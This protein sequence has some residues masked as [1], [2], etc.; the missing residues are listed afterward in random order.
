[1]TPAMRTPDWQSDDGAIQLHC[2]DCAELLPTI[3]AGAVDAV[4]TD[5]PYGIAWRGHNA[6]TRSWNGI[7]SDDG[8]L[9]L[10]PILSMGCTVV[11]FGANCYPEQLPHRGRWICWDKRTI[12]GAC[13][14]MLGSPFELAWINRKTGF[15]RIYRVMHGGVVNADGHN[16]KRVHPTQKPIALM[17]L[18]IKDFTSEGAIVI[19]PFMGSGTT[20]V[21]CIRTGR[22]F[23]GCE[24]SREYFD[25]AVKRIKREL[26]QPI[27]FAAPVDTHTQ[28]KMFGDEP[29]RKGR[30]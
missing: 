2:C 23:I 27:L 4:V 6:S 22:R 18:I 20:G 25:I 14:A 11:S 24:I 16:A 10:R 29:K 8:S 7:A 3:D 13:D 28:S 12:D 19:D 17:A 5:P 26:A 15:D 1:M 30:K 21:A 9:D